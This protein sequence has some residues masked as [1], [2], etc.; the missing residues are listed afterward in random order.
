MQ[1]ADSTAHRRLG[2]YTYL[3]APERLEH[4]AIMRVFCGTL[5]ADLAVPDVMAKLRETE[6]PADE[7]CG[8][9]SPSHRTRSPA[10]C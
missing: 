8:G 5:L 1:D 10:Q 6:G 2:A 7:H 9:W 4:I 3:S